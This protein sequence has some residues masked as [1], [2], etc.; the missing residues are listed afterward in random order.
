MAVSNLVSI[1]EF[2]QKYLEKINEKTLKPEN[3]RMFCLGKELKDDL[4]LYS[5]D[6]VDEMA[7][8]VMYKN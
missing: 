8:Q 1:L 2:K 4:C 5:Y 7:I 3:L 6:I